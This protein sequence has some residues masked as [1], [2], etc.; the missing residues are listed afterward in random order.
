M[1][2]EASSSSFRN[3]QRKWLLQF[4]Q[5]ARIAGLTLWLA[6]GW[7]VEA[8]D[9]EQHPRDHDDIDFF[10]FRTHS[11]VFHTRLN[12]KE[13][14]G[15]EEHYNGFASRRIT[16]FGK[17]I[18]R[19]TYLDLTTNSKLVTFLPEHTVNWPLSALPGDL[20]GELDG[21][22][23]PCF[24]WNMA[25]AE[26]EVRTFAVPDAPKSLDLAVIQKQVKPATR[27]SISKGLVVKYQPA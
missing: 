17:L 27:K 10:I 19:F 24:D 6:G 14:H 11:P 2:N 21:T 4:I 13:F 15:M 25:Y 22:P 23:I 9:R 5:E 20:L 16:P 7:A 26:S 12:R 3:Y 8:L 18:V 1:S